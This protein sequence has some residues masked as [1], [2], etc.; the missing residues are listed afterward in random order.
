MS[1]IL[2][3]KQKIIDYLQQAAIQAQESGK[4]PKVPLPIISIERPQ[5]PQHGDYATSFPLKLTRA[6]GIEP[7]V[8]ADIITKLIPQNSDI[9]AIEVAPPGFI[10][11]TRSIAV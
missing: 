11:F 4:L 1:E 5:N 6:A 7:L 9:A 10:N 8:I 3:A 2:S